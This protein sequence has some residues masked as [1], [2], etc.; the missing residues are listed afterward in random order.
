MARRSG[1]VRRL[2][3]GKRQPVTDE[4]FTALAKLMRL[5]ASGSREALRLVLVDGLSVPAA[6]QQ[7]GVPHQAVYKLQASAQ[8]AIEAARVVAG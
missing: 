2:G 4:Q 6:A 8:R 7:A 5:R 3:M 1:A